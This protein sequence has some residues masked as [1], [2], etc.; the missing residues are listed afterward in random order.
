MRKSGFFRL[1]GEKVFISEA[2]RREVLGLEEVDDG[3]WDI[4]YYAKHLGRFDIV[5]KHIFN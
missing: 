1:K 5:R 3:L 2:L 4:Y